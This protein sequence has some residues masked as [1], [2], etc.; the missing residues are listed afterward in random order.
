MTTYILHGGFPM[1]DNESNHA[2]YEE[3]ART[4]PEGGIVLLVFFAVAPSD[5]LKKTEQMKEL[6]EGRSRGKRFNYVTATKEDFLDQMKNADAI[7]LHGGDTAQ[8]LEVLK[9]YP[10]LKPFMEGKTVAGSSAGAYAL[11]RFGSAH[12]TERMR[13]GLGMVPVRLVCHYESPTLPPSINSVAELQSVAP[14]LEFV[15]LRDCEWKVFNVQSK[16]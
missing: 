7:Y 3:F 12:S 6:F 14:E 9:T 8:L 4:I 2:F 5:V 11:V 13:E 16:E 10:D 15:L 1:R